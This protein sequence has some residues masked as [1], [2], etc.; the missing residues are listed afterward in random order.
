[1]LSKNLLV[2]KLVDCNCIASCML[3]W[4]RVIELSTVVDNSAMKNVRMV[5]DKNWGLMIHFCMN[6]VSPT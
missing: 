5:D 4:D 3:S 1:M 6:L 2:C